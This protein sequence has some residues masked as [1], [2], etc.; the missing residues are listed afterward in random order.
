MIFNDGS[1]YEGDYNEGVPHG[2]GIFT[3]TNKE[4][5]KSFLSFEN[6]T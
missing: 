4:R 6:L 3:A 2:F 5:I 1:Y